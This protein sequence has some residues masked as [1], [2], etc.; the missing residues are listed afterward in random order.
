MGLMASIST[1]LAITGGIVIWFSK[2]LDDSKG[3]RSHIKVQSSFHIWRVVWFFLLWWLLWLIGESI[4]V[5]LWFTTV[6]TAIVGILLFYMWL[7]MLKIVP[8]ISKL[9]IHMPKARTKKV[10][11]VKNP[12]FAPIIWALTFFLPCG[13]TQAM[14]I[15]AISTWDFVQGAILMAMFAVWTAPVLFAVGMWSSYVKEHKV[16]ILSK[17]NPHI[18]F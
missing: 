9:W 7:H 17:I 2:Y 12:A 4:S 14:Q 3:V 1:C 8:N 11:T 6:L 18:L 15:F 5:S 16:R 10:L 13:F